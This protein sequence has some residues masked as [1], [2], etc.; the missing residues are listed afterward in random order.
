LKK[1]EK[2]FYDFHDS[3]NLKLNDKIIDRK[4]TKFFS[5]KNTIHVHTTLCGH[6]LF[7]DHTK[8]I[9]SINITV[10]YNIVYSSAFIS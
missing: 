2:Y 9:K 4:L 5:D 8:S 10:L 7:D 3:R 1:R 6:Q